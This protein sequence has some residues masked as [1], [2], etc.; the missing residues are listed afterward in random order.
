M[1]ALDR[2]PTFVD[3]L[4]R[5]AAG[6]GILDRI[7]FLGPRV[8][9]ELLREYRAAD[10]LVFPTRIEAYGMVVTEALAVGLPVI[11]TGVGGCPRRWARH[12]TAHRACWCP[13]TMRG[14]SERRLAPG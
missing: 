11:A 14:A 6:F 3:S 7:S 9:D 8:G 10:I 4:R 2:D 5:Q 1:G 13:P 12:P